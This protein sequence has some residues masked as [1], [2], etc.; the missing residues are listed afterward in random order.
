[1]RSGEH[2]GGQ[3]EPALAAL[4]TDA[5]HDDEHQQRQKDQTDTRQE[6]MEFDRD[7]V[8]DQAE[9]GLAAQQAAH[10]VEQGEDDDRPGH[11]DGPL[12]FEPYPPDHHPYRKKERLIHNLQDG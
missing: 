9:D 2:D 3:G 1:M 7:R 10:Q 12:E 5:E 11:P 8:R 4:L 6:E